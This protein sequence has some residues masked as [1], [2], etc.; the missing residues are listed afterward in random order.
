MHIRQNRSIVR[1]AAVAAGILLFAICGCDKKRSTGTQ[2]STNALSTSGPGVSHPGQRWVPGMKKTWGLRP[3]DQPGSIFHVEYSANTSI[4]DL[5][6]V[7]RT[8]RGV[9]ADHRI[10][11]FEDSPELRAR[12][13]PGKYVLFEGLDLRKVD[14]Y[15]VD[16]KSKN[17]IVGTEKAS[18]SQA[19]K[20]A[21]VRFKMP[22]NFRDIFQQYAAQLE[23][24]PPASAFTDPLRALSEWLQPPVFADIAPNNMEGAFEYADTDFAVWKIQYHFYVPGDSNNMHLDL[25]LKREANGLNVDLSAKAQMNN[26]IQQA[27]LNI[28]DNGVLQFDIRDLDFDSDMDLDWTIKTSENKTPMNEVRFKLPKPARIS[29]PLMEFTELPM[30]LDISEALLFHPAFTTKEEVAKGGFHI[31]YSGDEGFSLDG[32]QTQVEG[33]GE[34]DG[35]INQSFAFSPFAS[36]GL[37]VAVAMPRVELRMGTDELWDMAEIPLPSAL[38]ESLSDVLLNNTIAGQWVKKQMGNPLEIEG[39]AYL[40]MVIST[41][42][43]HSGEQ[44]LV[45][46]QQFTLVATG[47]TGVDGTWLG[48]NSNIPPKDLFTKNI[49]QR[50]PDSKIC[51]GDK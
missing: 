32:S 36:F 14:A 7:G 26:F 48:K 45:P 27:A 28:G 37:V 4:V 17:L 31:N 51:G 42:A 19:L 35:A 46:C 18:L 3:L 22:V 6:T 2:S 29:I 10:F 43:A 34:G 1:L 13:I 5:A 41:T 8:F 40:Q 49:V 30:S 23:P 15:A 11:L 44:S 16:P 33:Q 25:Q 24:S 21:Q 47:Q 50:Q 12:L 9:S 39:A 38:T 20:S